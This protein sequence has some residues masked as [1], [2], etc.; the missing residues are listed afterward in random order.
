MNNSCQVS[1]WNSNVTWD[2]MGEGNYWSDYAGVD[3]N[4][5]GIGDTPYV[6]LNGGAD[7]YP[8]MTPHTA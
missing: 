2:F 7:N 4:G 6:I 5:D 8:L 3:A 1:Q